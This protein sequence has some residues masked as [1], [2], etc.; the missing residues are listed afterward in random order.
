MPKWTLF[1]LALLV[2]QSPDSFARRRR[3]RQQAPYCGNVV[4]NCDQHYAEVDGV[5][6]ALDC[7]RSTP[8]YRSGWLEGNIRANGGLWRCLAGKPAIN[9]GLGNVIVHTPCGGS[10]KGQNQKFKHSGCLNVSQAVLNK[11]QQCT[12]AH[13]Q[14]VYETKGTRSDG[15]MYARTPGQLDYS[16]WASAR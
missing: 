1:I 6:S 15:Y 7:G 2:L 4:F 13:Y 11:L 5:R 16:Q 14:I 8:T 3:H 9:I 10:P 12:G